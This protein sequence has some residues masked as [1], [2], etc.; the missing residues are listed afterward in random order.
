MIC[1]RTALR[2]R[3]HKRRLLGVTDPLTQAQKSPRLGRPWMMWVGVLKG[4]HI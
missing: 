1:T 2:H 3:L 4:L